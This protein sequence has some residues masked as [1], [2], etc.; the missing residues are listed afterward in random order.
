MDHDFSILEASGVSQRE[1]SELVGVCRL[2]VNRWVGGARVTAR[3]E[4]AVREQLKRL[5]V[6]IK[7]GILP[8][9][10]AFPARCA[11]DRRAEAFREALRLTDLRSEQAQSANA[12]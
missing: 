11:L 4:A 1:F 10:L 3:H 2:T 9:A 5:S 12:A 6:A 8:A 7:L